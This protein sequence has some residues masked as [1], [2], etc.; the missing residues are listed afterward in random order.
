M[1]AMARIVDGAQTQVVLVDAEAVFDL[2]KPDV[3]LPE[4]DGIPVFEVGAQQVTAIGQFGPLPVFLFG[5]D[6]DRKTL[7][8][9]MAG[10]IAFADVDPEEAGRARVLL[11]QAAHTPLR[12]TPATQRPIKPVVVHLLRR[13]TQQ[14]VQGHLPVPEL[15]DLQFRR[16][17]TKPGYRG[18][19]LVTQVNEE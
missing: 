8:A 10:I 3:G 7:A 17:R 9:L 1:R 18:A 15:R 4:R 11:E 19:C 16:W 2:G 6:A 13:H 14:V 12:G 5:L